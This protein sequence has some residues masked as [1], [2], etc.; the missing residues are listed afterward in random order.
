MGCPIGQ[1]SFFGTSNKYIKFLSG[2][3]VA[4]DGPNL[5]EKQI[6][7]DLRIPYEQTLRGRVVLK[8]GQV[9]YLMNHLGL[10]DNATLLSISARYNSKSVIS[11]DNYVQYNYY[12]DLTKTYTFA[13]LLILTGTSTSRIPQLYLTNP[14]LT[15]SVTL[16]VL[17]ANVDDT[18]TFFPDVINQSGLSFTNLKYTS[19][20]TFVT[21]ESIVIYDDNGA[22]L[23]Y[24]TIR[25]ITSIDISNN[26]LIIKEDAIGS[27]FL[28][29]IDLSNAMIANSL[30]NFI[31]NNNGVVIDGN[32]PYV[33]DNPPVVSFYSYVG[34]TSS[35]SY[36]EFNGMTAGVPYNTSNGLTFS[37]NISFG[38]YSEFSKMDLKYLLIDNVLDSN[39]GYLNISDSEI[40]LTGASGG[41]FSIIS[42][43]G[44]Y[45]MGFNITNLAGY[46]VDPATNIQLTINN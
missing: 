32:H 33:Y 6:L 41:S 16:D 46:S 5:V 44:S 43:T 38:T 9:N 14:S 29:F 13:Q 4:T 21:D 26:I 18:Y 17:V 24:L 40:T 19:I 15:Y 30:L 3:L 28:E 34:N 31:L 11:S 2:D 12:P 23:C 35:N 10:G 8:A 1:N 45:V 37:T 39:D 25:G 27:L 36:I 22:S 20:N 7:N 42:Y